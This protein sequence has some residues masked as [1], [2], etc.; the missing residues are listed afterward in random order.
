LSIIDVGK[1]NDVDPVITH[2]GAKVLE[3]FCGDGIWRIEHCP[4]KLINH[5]SALQKN[6]KHYYKIRIVSK[7]TNR[8][9]PAPCYVGY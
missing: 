1:G 2:N 5:Y 8:G 3:C 4:L 6:T 9:I 7:Q